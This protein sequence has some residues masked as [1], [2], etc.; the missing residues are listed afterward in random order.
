[1]I[2]YIKGF[3]KSFAQLQDGD[4]RKIIWKSAFITF[5]AYVVLIF[6]VYWLV[7]GVDYSNGYWMYAGFLG[8]FLAVAL[9][10]IFFP[11]MCMV[12]TTFFLEE[13]A[14]AVEKRY[15]YPIEINRE[16]SFK[17]IIITGIKF[18]VVSVLLNLLVLPLYF[19]PI[20][21]VVALYSING[22]LIGREYFEIVALRKVD[23][24]QTSSLRKS[25]SKSILMAG[26]FISFLMTIP[27]FNLFAPVIGIA[28]MV[29]KFEELRNKNVYV[30]INQKK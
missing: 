13:V 22:Y 1:M 9:S 3:V 11:T 25:S 18:A 5:V 27:L 23:A 16:Q 8:G 24:E 30:Q 2:E 10:L 19:I 26:A 7:S 14:D 29:H 20:L 28:F 15:G 6:T 12:V 21:N 4:T 17:E